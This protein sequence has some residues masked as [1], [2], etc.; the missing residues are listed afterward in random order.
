MVII[1]CFI[2]MLPHGAWIYIL[3]FS[4]GAR[5]K[6]IKYPLLLKAIHK[7]V[8]TYITLDP[9]L[10][11]ILS[12]LSLILSRSLMRISETSF[13]REKN[14]KNWFTFVHVYFLVSSWLSIVLVDRLLVKSRHWLISLLLLYLTTLYMLWLNWIKTTWYLTC[15]PVTQMKIRSTF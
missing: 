4:D 11:Q 6:F 3:N 12:H 13:H 9:F 14:C 7:Y 2:K 8:S 1:K 10:L 5:G 15:R